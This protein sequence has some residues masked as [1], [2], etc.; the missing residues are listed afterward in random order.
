MT[1]ELKAKP[2]VLSAG[3]LTGDKVKNDLGEDLGKIEE[4]MIDLQRGVVAYAV[5]SFGGFLGMGD[6]LFAVPWGAMK[7]DLE[8]KAFILNVEKDVLKEAPGFDKDDWPD[9]TDRDYGTKV[10]THFKVVPYWQS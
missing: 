4:I 1:K 10:Y 7:L 5:V 2:H 3:S 6:K 8:D 9:F